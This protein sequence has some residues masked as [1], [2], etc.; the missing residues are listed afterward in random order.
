MDTA[1][2][3]SSLSYSE[4]SM[5]GRFRQIMPHFIAHPPLVAIILIT[6]YTMTLVFEA[7]RKLFGNSAMPLAEEENLGFLLS[8]LL[9]SRPKL[10][11]LVTFCQF[12]D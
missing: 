4:E 2:S 5:A 10:K 9:S 7:F 8:M 1:E 3:Y 12:S 11:G 6:R